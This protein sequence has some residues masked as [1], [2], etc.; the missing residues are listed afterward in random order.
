MGFPKEELMA[1]HWRS[2]QQ[3]LFEESPPRMRLPPLQWAKAVEQLQALLME[4]M[5]TLEDRREAGDDED[6]A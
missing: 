3:D 1:K 5:A 6:H 2:A 4:A